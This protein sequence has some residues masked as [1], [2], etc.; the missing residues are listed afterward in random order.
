MGAPKQKWTAEEEAALKAGVVKHGAGKWRTIL[1]DPEFSA[2]LRMRSNVDLKDKWRNIN[3]TAIWGSRQKA[4][5]AL[6][7]SLP[8]PKIDN[9]HMALSTVVQHDE[10]LDTKPLA[11]SGG[12]LQSP[13]FKEQISRLVDNHILEAIVNMKEQKGSDKGAIISYMEEKYR[14]PPNISK[15]LSTKLKHMVASGK[16]IKEK[17]RYRIASSSAVSE[18]R[19]SSSLEGRSKDHS[20]ANK[21]D[22]V[23]ILSKSQI[24]KEISKVKGL[25]AQEAAAAAAKAVAEAEAAIAQAEA[26]AREAEAAEAEAEA[27]QVFAKAAMKALKCKMLHI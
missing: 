8:A 23:N 14:C 25:T 27:A 19:R 21:N 3:V 2:I 24:D 9:N 6:K 1:T 11:V 5:L 17:H 16:I 20:E 13:N 22:D 18:K 26:A 4:K 15:L 10:V 7:R 12:P